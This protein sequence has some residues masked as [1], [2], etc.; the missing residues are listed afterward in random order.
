MFLLLY[1]TRRLIQSFGI[2]IPQKYELYLALIVGSWIAF[3][4]I[5]RSE[6]QNELVE[7]YKNLNGLK[8]NLFFLRNIYYSKPNGSRTIQQRNNL[9]VCKF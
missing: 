2:K 9:S 8:A 5:R 3:I 7:N 6:A 4:V 1:S